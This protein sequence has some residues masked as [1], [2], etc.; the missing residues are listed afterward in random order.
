M[1]RTLIQS[2]GVTAAPSGVHGRTA[3]RRE[4]GAP[5]RRHSRDRACATPQRDTRRPLAPGY[6]LLIAAGGA[7]ALWAGLAK[8]VMMAL[9]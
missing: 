7:L 2:P 8:L 9:H 3:R 4:I 1:V 6:G 5:T